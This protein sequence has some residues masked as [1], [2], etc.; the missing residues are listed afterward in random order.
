MKTK[1][2]WIKDTSESEYH[3]NRTLKRDLMDE[4]SEA[5]EYFYEKYSS[6]FFNDK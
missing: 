2:N 4:F 1:Y 3:K 5:N 6:S